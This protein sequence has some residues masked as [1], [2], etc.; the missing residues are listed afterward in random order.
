MRWR[1]VAA[2][3]AILILG[4]PLAGCVAY[5]GPTGARGLGTVSTEELCIREGNVLD[6]A[7]VAQE[8]TRRGVDCEVYAAALM[9]GEPDDG[10]AWLG[11]RPPPAWTPGTPLPPPVPLGDAPRDRRPPPPMAWPLPSRAFATG[12]D[13][14]GPVT[15]EPL[16]EAEPGPASPSSR[17][18]P[19]AGSPVQA[20]RLRSTAPPLP[21]P[22][23]DTPPSRT[24]AAA[25]L[26]TTAAVTAAPLTTPACA[27]RLLRRGEAGGV[28]SSRRMVAF[29]NRCDHPIRVLYADRPNGTLT[30]LTPLLR[31]GE[32]SEAARIQDGFDHPGYV[33]CS[34]RT[35]PEGAACRLDGGA[36][37]G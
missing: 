31:P 26:G 14:V 7:W 30:E 20:Q 34:Y 19:G 23:A 1:V 37:P 33:V 21:A 17:S 25:P 32:S 13:P 28:E 9:G 12:A 6:G 22:A 2:V 35:A 16:P 4:G 18:P 15:Q 3:A 11:S 8:I 27:E 24:A 29:R 36:G 10:R 5:Q